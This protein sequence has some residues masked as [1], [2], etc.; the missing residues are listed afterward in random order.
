MIINQGFLGICTKNTLITKLML[1]CIGSRFTAESSTQGC[2]AR[3]P[4]AAD[5]QG[6]ILYIVFVRV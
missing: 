3:A 5:C 2:R 6:V 4:S 1:F